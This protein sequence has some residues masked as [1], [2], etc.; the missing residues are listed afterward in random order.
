MV[1]EW[2]FKNMTKRTGL[3]AE[4]KSEEEIIDEQMKALEREKERLKAQNH[5][6][7]DLNLH[8]NQT[9]LYDFE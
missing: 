1:I 3:E 8:E 5:R 2:D 9:T 6:P 7:A 4:Y